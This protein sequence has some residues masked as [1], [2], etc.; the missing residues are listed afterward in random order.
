MSKPKH[1]LESS[2][3]KQ[4]VLELSERL[5]SER[6]EWIERNAWYYANDHRHMRF[7]VPEGVRV[8]DLGCGTG[9]LLAELKPSRGVGVDLSPQMISCASSKYPDLEFHV[10]DVEQPNVLD[11]LRGPFDCIILSDTIGTLD[12]CETTLGLLHP[13][14]TRDS[15]V[16]V[17]Y[18]SH[19]W[20]PL[21]Y[22]A[23]KAGDRMPQ[24]TD[25]NWLS[26]KDIC[27]LLELADFDVVKYDRRQLC[28]KHL[29]GLG[30]LINSF[31]ATLP[32]FSRLCLRNYIVASSS[33]HKTSPPLSA[34]IVI[35][36]RNEA[37]HIEQAI[38]RLPVFC[39]DQEIL[40]VEGH[41]QDNTWSEIKRVIAAYPDLDIK[42]SQQSGIG[43]GDAVRQGFAEARGEV[44]MIL[45]A[46]L[47]VPPETLPK[48]YNALIS[49]RGDFVM[50]TR[51]VY[52]VEKAAMRFLN[53][54]AN[55][56][57]A[58]LFSW[59]L[60]QRITDTLCGTKVLRR[61]DYEKIDATRSYFGNLDPFGDFD[62]ILGAAKL[63]LRIIEIPIRYQ[64]REYG[65]TQIS[66]F[67]HGWMLF[68][69]FLVAYRKLQAS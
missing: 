63:N 13:L 38:Q 36:C 65:E 50:G 53:Y 40:F 29:L 47:T 35:P 28:P 9:R 24:A 64:A 54:W 7:L 44:L 49:G 51:L 56:T 26:T 1:L 67:K 22:L 48:F 59:L 55:R 11:Q 14:C 21:L 62:L 45:D 69:M 32:L 61:T 12:D 27:A 52:P 30:S 20:E 19:L 15:R 33:R 25:L 18:Y 10:G 58:A 17:T 57:F 37:G 8:L 42:A 3:R 31:L 68:K 2:K 23:E 60:R 6:D 41:S 4:A 5:A 43:K 16:I 46:D 66:R 34:T 39:E